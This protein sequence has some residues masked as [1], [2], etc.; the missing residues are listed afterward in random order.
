MSILAEIPQ[1]I[2][3]SADEIRSA[4]ESVAIPGYTGSIQLQVLLAP[5]AAKYITIAVIRRQVSRAEHESPATRQVLP[6]AT[7]RKPVE[8]VIEDIKTRLRIR[9]VL[10]ALEVQ[11]ADGILQKKTIQE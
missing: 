3:F 1:G 5:E 7:R 8:S 9:T 2:P 6:D 4:L 10:T 11:V